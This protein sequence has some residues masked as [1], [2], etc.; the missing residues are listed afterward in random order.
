MSAV[1]LLLPVSVVSSLA[2]GAAGAQARAHGGGHEVQVAGRLVREVTLAHDAGTEAE[3]AR[4]WRRAVGRDRSLAALLDGTLALLAFRADAAERAYRRAMT[5]SLSPAAAYAMLGMAGVQAT[6]APIEPVLAL[7]QG[8]ESRFARLGDSVG[9]VEALMAQAGPAFR[10]HS[11]DSALS[12][13]AGAEQLVPLVDPWLRTRLECLRLQVQ[14]RATRAVEDSALRRAVEA[15]RAVGPRAHAECLFTRALALEFRGLN[16]PAVSVLDTAAAVQR[17]ARLLG[18]LSATRQWQGSM[19]LSR[20]FHAEARAALVEALDAARRSGSISGEAWATNELGRVAQRLGADAEAA[21]RFAEARDLFAQAGDRLGLAYTEQSLANGLLLRGDLAAADSAFRRNAEVHDAVAPATR[22]PGLV[23]RADIA[24][25]QQA[26]T[27]ARLLLDSAQVLAARRNLPG[28]TSEIRYHRGLVALAAGS[29]SA[30]IAQWDTLLTQQRALRGPMRFE[31]VSRWAEAA[32]AAGRL[33]LAWINFRMAH[34]GYD[35]WRTSLTHREDALAALQDR[36]FDWDRDLDFA[37]MITRFAAAG[38]AGEALAMAEWRRLRT[39][40]QQAL[41]RGAL[42][43]AGDEPRAIGVP[44]VDTAGLDPAR[45]PALARARLAPSH[46]VVA[47]V[48]GGGGEPTT[49]FLLSRDSLVTVALPP[50]DSL[51]EPITRFLAFLEAGRVPGPLGRQLADAVL[52]PVLRAVP[53]GTTRLVL[54][55][56]GVLHRLPFAAL[57]VAEG[58]PLLTRFELALAPSVE[59]A[60]GSAVAV[61]RAPGAQSR[62]LVVG[63]PARMPRAPDGR[64]WPALPGARSE[65]RA[66]ATALP[67][68]VLLEGRRAT[69]P[70]V[71]GRLAS[72]GLVLHVA[73]HAVADPGT[74]EGSGLVLQPGRGG[75]G[76]LSVGDLAAQPLPFDL[77]VLSACASADGVL[78]A[79]QALHGL[80]STVLDA[81]ARGAVATRWQVGDA[82]MAGLMRRFYA[83]LADTS[84]VVAALRQAR[85]E[86][87]RDGASPALWAAVEYHGDPGLRLETVRPA[88]RRSS[89]VG[90]PARGGFGAR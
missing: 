56:D 24:R 85:L 36:Y 83:A 76:L 8:A 4:R 80:V 41:Q 40:E 70:A 74:V 90:E 15:A 26:F 5:D 69:V 75:R 25:R 14:V 30:A 45:L 81:G 3:A 23:A 72:G 51:A 82:G 84:D 38:R 11:P 77:V 44:A 46:V 89:G 27:E 28:W 29:P 50:V 10:L 21:R 33:D 60:L 39:A 61:A 17:G 13:L 34:Q 32:A 19:L 42:S 54:V 2:A 9:R 49:A 22:V 73:T 16:Q 43:L 37:T 48:T 88:P 55:P 71:K 78:Y 20:G 58:A 59:D 63:A 12:L 57:P 66:V 47:F 31:V 6:R 18:A 67:G 1:R 62:S 35:R 52:A 87:L 64:P 65:V 86:A 68:A 79:G 53:A 7:L